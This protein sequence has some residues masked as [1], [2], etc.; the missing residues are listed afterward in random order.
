M[1]EK[2]SQMTNGVPAQSADV[3]PVVR[4]GANLQVTAASIAG[5]ASGGA[6]FGTAGQGWLDAIQNI[7]FITNPPAGGTPCIIS[8]GSNT[9]NANEVTCVQ[10]ELLYTITVRKISLFVVTGAGSGFVTCGIFNA[11]GT[12]LLIDAGGE[13]V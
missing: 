1:S 12:T 8:N 13:R 4:S 7:P 6:N 10:F 2:I 3:V 5:L 11:A 9:V